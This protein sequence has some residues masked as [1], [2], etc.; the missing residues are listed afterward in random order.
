M[1]GGGFVGGGT[2]F[3]PPEHE[4]VQGAR[5]EQTPSTV[6]R[7]VCDAGTAM[8]FGGSVWHAGIAVEAG[9]RVCLVASFS[10]LDED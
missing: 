2:G 6:F 3:W 8:L 9:W 10:P 4:M 7:P 5:G 1:A